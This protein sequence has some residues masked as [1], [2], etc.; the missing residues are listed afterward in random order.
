MAGAAA[1]AA[2]VAAGAGA[3][4]LC[5]LGNIPVMAATP[6]MLTSITDAAAHAIKG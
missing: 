3:V 6:T 1:G 5:E 4:V 2:K